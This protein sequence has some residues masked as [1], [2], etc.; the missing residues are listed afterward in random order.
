[1]KKG[2][3]KGLEALISFENNNTSIEDS[4]KNNIL[5]IK[6]T[7]IEPNMLQPRK[8]FNEE[9]LESMAQSIRENGI[10]QPLIV[11][12]VNNKYEIIAGE[13][14]WRASRIAGLTKVPVVIKNMSDKQVME[15]ALIENLQREDLNVIEEAKGYNLL[16][17]EYS[18]TQE[19]ISK[20]IG[21]NRSTIAN[22]LRLITLDIRVQNM[23]VEEKLS[24][25]HARTLV[26]VSDSQTQYEIAKNIVENQL[27]VRETEK[28]L[29]SIENKR[30]INRKQKVYNPIYLEIEDNLKSVLGTKVKILDKKNKGKIEIEYYS[31][32]DLERIINLLQK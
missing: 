18:L 27:T 31:N 19:E 17:K 6:I 3:G 4:D 20:I 9:K 8:N 13:R 1:M 28:L 16:M 21:K 25:G 23:I 10:I 15:A 30:E 12:R 7:D 2:L 11:R 26:V 32:D 5:E 22:T 14:R 29:K 24:S